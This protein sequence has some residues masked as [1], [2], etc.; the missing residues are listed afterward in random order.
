MLFIRSVVILHAICFLA[1]LLAALPAGAQ[2]VQV[3]NLS[4]F[5]NSNNLAP[6]LA[7]MT[8][9]QIYVSSAFPHG[10]IIDKIMFRYDEV[11]GKKNGID[12]DLQIAF[13][14]AATTVATASP[15]FADN[16]GD[17]V[18][19]VLDGRVTESNVSSLPPTGFG[20][21]FDV[22]D[23][24]HY[25]PSRGDLLVQ[26]LV[27]Q[28]RLLVLDASDVPQQNVTT[29]IF[30]DGFDTT[31]GRVGLGDFGPGPYGLVTQFQFVPESSAIA[32]FGAMLLL[33]I[34]YRRRHE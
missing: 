7:P 12:A 18:T 24:F 3:P 25:D 34:A 9:Q 33:L 31:T 4:G 6:F 16:I 27:R 5:G 1:G 15:T 10:G 14:Y 2:L 23:T 26:F 30:A 28:S 20:L 21:I 8:Y 19:I 11:F 17:D 32:Q 13:A 22:A 29:R